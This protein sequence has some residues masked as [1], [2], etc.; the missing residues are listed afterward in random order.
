[1]RLPPPVF[2]YLVVDCTPFLTASSV[3]TQTLLAFLEFARV[4]SLS[5]S[6]ACIVMLA[7]S[8]VLFFCSHLVHGEVVPDAVLPAIGA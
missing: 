3:S 7:W 6:N 1:M 2:R 5:F 4:V 8:C